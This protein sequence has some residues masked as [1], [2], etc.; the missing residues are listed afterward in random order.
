MTDHV[1]GCVI[2]QALGTI[3]R[4][5]G[6]PELALLTLFAFTYGQGADLLRK[7]LCDPHRERLATYDLI[8]TPISRDG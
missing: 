8:V 5:P 1:S 7:R 6:D 4:H 3:E 2:C